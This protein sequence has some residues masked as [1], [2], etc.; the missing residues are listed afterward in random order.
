MEL[1]QLRYF[2]AV[3]EERHFSRAA[4]RLHLSQPPLSLQIRQLEEKIGVKLF[5]RSTRR[6]D[7][8]DAGRTLL[9]RARAILA[10]AE[11]ARGAA[12]E[13]T[14]GLQG[15]LEVGFVSSATLSLLPPAL[16]LFRERFGGVGLE[17]R[18]L[19]S[20]QQTEALHEGDIRVGLVRLPLEAPGIEIEAVLE[21]P[22]LVA[23]P[24]G[25]PLE[26]LDR[27]PVEEMVDY[28]LVFFSRQLVPGFHAQIV[29]LFGSVG[30]VPTV[31]Q[32]AVHLQTIVGL[33]AGG[34]GLAI[35]PGS[36]TRVRREGV[37]YRPLDAPGAT[38][39][40]GLAW[41]RE[42]QSELA[43]NFVQTVREVAEAGG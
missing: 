35:L 28:P 27:V 20:A 31:A 12:R 34:L 21:E 19:T 40:L 13:T 43:R 2:V 22:L 24:S 1:R 32:Y 41:R 33:V 42:D 23:I 6:V 37:T 7:L 14:L 3:A 38:S 16:R 30:A 29:E 26:K 9:T 36:A 25:H 39:W 18:E 11:E 4:R 15:M 10:A 17:L 5:E 8:T